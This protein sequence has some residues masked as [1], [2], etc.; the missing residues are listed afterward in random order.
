M[1][2]FLLLLALLGCAGRNHAQQ[3]SK[4][5]VEQ[6]L[7]W[8][9]YKAT[10]RFN[11]RWSVNM[12]V[13]ER[14]FVN[15][16]AQHQSVFRPTATRV[17]GTGWDLGAGMCLYLQS[18]NDP[19][20]PSYL[21]VPELRPHVELNGKQ[22]LR[23]FR[24]VQRI[25]AEAR[26]FHAVEGDALG[27]GYAFRNFRLRCRIGLDVPLVTAGA[28]RLERLGFAASDE[29]LVNAGSRILY[30]VFDQ[31]R[32]YLGLYSAL[33]PGLTIELGY[34]NW[35]QQRQSGRDF[36]DRHI[37]RLGVNQKFGRAMRAP[38]S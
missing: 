37:L 27:E 12:D 32:V 31:N 38:K 33:S 23:Y 25:K 1:P 9:A 35:F 6:E 36:Y 15:P 18:P 11:D 14:F 16:A 3:T 8:L 26:Y 17:L 2:R 10:Y 13:Q 24:V 4:N 19:H 34:L 21:V 22:Q 29:L 28:G 7:A 30:N 20:A 5:V